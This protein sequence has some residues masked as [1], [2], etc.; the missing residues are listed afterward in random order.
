MTSS[1]DS[2]IVG[3]VLSFIWFVSSPCI[4]VIVIVGPCLLWYHLKNIV[5]VLAVWFS[6]ELAYVGKQIGS[7]IWSNKQQGVTSEGESNFVCNFNIKQEDDGYIYKKSNPSCTWIAQN[8]Y[9]NVVIEN[10]MHKT[11]HNMIW[12]VLR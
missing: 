5:C 11:N 10:K 8:L 3:L 2:K 4:V 1:I 6:D 9:L 12:D 7:Y